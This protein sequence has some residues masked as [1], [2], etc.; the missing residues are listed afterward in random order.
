MAECDPEL[1]LAPATSTLLAVAID[2][3]RRLSAYVAYPYA[4][5]GMCKKYFQHTHFDNE[6]KFLHAPLHDLDVGVGQQLYEMAWKNG[7]QLEAMNW[8]LTKAWQFSLRTS[9]I[10]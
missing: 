7:S 2:L 3:E 6:A 4:I 10:S 9:E 1:D 5:C 8:L